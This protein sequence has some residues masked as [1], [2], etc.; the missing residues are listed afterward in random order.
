MIN[1][2]KRIILRHWV[3]VSVLICHFLFGWIIN[4]G[5]IFAKEE[6]QILN[7]LCFAPMIWMGLTGLLSCSLQ[8]IVFTYALSVFGLV[9]MMFIG[10]GIIDYWPYGIWI[11]TVLST[12]TSRIDNKTLLYI[13][14][15]MFVIA[16]WITILAAIRSLIKHDRA[17]SIAMIII[18]Y[19]LSLTAMVYYYV[20]L[21]D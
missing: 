18:G 12:S 4:G 3:Y 20:P 15:F 14:A 10:Y 1:T 7:L 21:P 19:M 6:G 2:A 9:S 5:W 16:A 17:V 11:P 8:S 13:V